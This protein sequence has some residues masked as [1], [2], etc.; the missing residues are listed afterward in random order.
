LIGSQPDKDARQHIDIALEAGKRLVFCLIRGHQTATGEQKQLIE[1][2]RNNGWNLSKE[3]W[4]LFE[5]RSS[6]SLRQDLTAFLQPAKS[7]PQEQPS[8]TLVYILCDPTTA[9]DARFAR[10]VQEKIQTQEKF[11]VE[12]P[13]TAAAG[14][15]RVLHEQR[16][17]ACDGLLFYHERAPE[18][19]YKRNLAD[20]LV[21]EEM[22]GRRELKSKAMLVNH[23]DIRHPG[24]TVI[25][26]RDPFDLQ[27]LEPFLSPLRLSRQ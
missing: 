4:A 15:P 7:A 6:A 25:Q 23:L 26:R 19:W 24:L 9:D 10:E 12:L 5:S 1:H 21:A 3:R 11:E 16:L 14:S 13:Q 8:N 17:R 27:Q 2:I 20:L 18:Q 22:E